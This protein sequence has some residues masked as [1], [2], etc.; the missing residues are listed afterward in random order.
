M[1]GRDRCPDEVRLGVEQ[2]SEVLAE[3]DQGLAYC[4][5]VEVLVLR[6]A[7][8][9]DWNRHYPCDDAPSPVQPHLFEAH[10]RGCTT[11]RR[12]YVQKVDRGG[13]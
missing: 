5:G 10:S 9:D 6:T 13:P 8:R 7:E 12:C 4:C 3:P 2:S 11:S 1:C